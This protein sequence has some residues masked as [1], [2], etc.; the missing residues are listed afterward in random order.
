MKDTSPSEMT[1]FRHIMIGI[2][3]QQIEDDKNA[4]EMLKY[5]KEHYQIAKTL[6]TQYAHNPKKPQEIILKGDRYILNN[7]NHYQYTNAIALKEVVVTTSISPL[8]HILLWIKKNIG[9][10]AKELKLNSLPKKA[11]L[12]SLSGTYNGHFIKCNRYLFETIVDLKN[13]KFEVSFRPVKTVFLLSIFDPHKDLVFILETNTYEG[14]EYLA[15]FIGY[16]IE[17]FKATIIQQYKKAITEAGNDKDKLDIVYEIIPDFILTLLKTD[18]Q[19]YADIWT[20]LDQNL[21]DTLGRDEN[22]GILN[23]LKTLQKKNAKKLYEKLYERPLW[24]MRL[25]K[26]F[27]GDDKK[28]FVA[29]IMDLCRY[30]KNAPGANQKIYL[31]N[32]Y[33]PSNLQL[34]ANWS[35]NKIKIQNTITILNNLGNAV[36]YSTGGLFPSAVNEHKKIYEGAPLNPMDLIGVRS[37]L[38]IDN[39]KKLT[40]E[41]NSN[42]VALFIKYKVDELFQET[43]WDVVNVATTLAGGYGAIE[44]LTIEGTGKLLKTLVVIELTK[45]I[46]DLVMLSDNAKK[47][48]KEA[49]L[50]VIVDNW[51]TISITADLTFLSLDLLISLAKYGRKGAKVLKDI[52]EIEQ[53]AHLEKQT[54]KA[55]IEIE[56]QTGVNVSKMS[57]K[58]INE[59]KKILHELG[60]RHTRLETNL[61][62]NLEKSDDLFGNIGE[63][64]KIEDK[65][66][67]LDKEHGMFFDIEGK[68]LLEKPF[69]ENHGSIEI[70]DQLSEAIK[71][72]RARGGRFTDLT[73]T[74]NH[75]LS[76]ALSP[77]DILQAILN[78]LKEIRAVG[79]SGIDY[80]LKRIKHYPPKEDIIKM[81]KKVNDKMQ[82]KYPTLHPTKYI[83]GGGNIEMAQFYAETL[84]EQFAG[85]IKYTKFTK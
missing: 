71:E 28:N 26:T 27:S 35:Q 25:Y 5:V 54:E 47:A 33:W 40:K 14:L 74:H 59:T 57:E 51:T 46:V 48:L 18:Q 85:Y 56:R 62:K 61:A 58:E 84:L 53:A 36:S 43:F 4:E 75:Y 79:K 76:S 72:N 12:D 82:S 70:K 50:G 29:L 63:V 10:K 32:S 37:T 13:I 7:E 45:T 38:E 2:W 80:S 44:I 65:I 39:D 23:I 67:I 17:A 55:F 78:N 52:N 81:L 69:G 11:L 24:V 73:F 21:S 9:N 3:R 16:D 20:L 49:G 83:N 41:A 42:Q 15:Q 66:R 22:K 64:K 19:M 31:P 1:R 77:S 30:N 68:P 60:E 34:T 8:V 6:D